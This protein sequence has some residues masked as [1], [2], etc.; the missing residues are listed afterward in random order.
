MGELDLGE[1][2]DEH[3]Q[4]PF[5]PL[6]LLLMALVRGQTPDASSQE[7]LSRTLTIFDTHD[8]Y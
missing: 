3:G 8:G 1:I 5:S 6:R 4:D 7:V 2:V